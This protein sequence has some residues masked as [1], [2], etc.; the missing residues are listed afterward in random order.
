MNLP[1]R[2]RTVSPVL[3]LAFCV[4]VFSG[5]ASGPR[6]T[7]L[8]TRPTAFAAAHSRPAKDV[9]VAVVDKREDRSLDIILAKQATEE[10]ADSIRAGL[11]DSKVITIAADGGDT[12]EVTGTLVRLDWFVPNYQSMLKKA[13]ATSFLTGGIGGIAY[14]STSTPVQGNAVIKVTVT[15]AGAELLSR[16]YAGLHEESLAKLKCDTLE[17]KSRVAGLAVAD[18]VDKFLKDFDQLGASDA[19]AVGHA[20]TEQPSPAAATP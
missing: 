12:W 19:S 18:A 17:T 5:C 8:K 11:R 13:F 9:K 1:S 15:R 3:L 2:L 4:A 6:T 14:G 10:V 20:A 7:A 16:E